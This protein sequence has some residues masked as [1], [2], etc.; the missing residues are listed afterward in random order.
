MSER[1]DWPHVADFTELGVDRVVQSPVRD[2]SRPEDGI[3]TNLV[4][5]PVDLKHFVRTPTRILRRQA[6]HLRRG[7]HG[8]TVPDSIVYSKELGLI[9]KRELMDD[10]VSS[11]GLPVNK[12][13]ARWWSFA[14]DKPFS[15]NVRVELDLVGVPVI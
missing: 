5:H 3:L 7:I 8:G 6:T 10:G 12:L 15:S 11:Y 9:L 4:R 13:I 14:L 1:K 2:E